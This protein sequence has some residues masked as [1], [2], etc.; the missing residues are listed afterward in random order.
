[1]WNSAITRRALARMTAAGVLGSQMRLGAANRKNPAVSKAMASMLQAEQLAA[2][3]PWRP[4]YHFH[5]PANWMNDP[6]GTIFYKGWHHLFY[7]CNPYGAEWGHMH[8]GTCKIARP[9]E[10]GT[11]ADC[12]LAFDREG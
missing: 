6:N 7:Q 9:G 3:D 12:A 5:P 10:L 2:R 4:V 11:V 1:M 8:W